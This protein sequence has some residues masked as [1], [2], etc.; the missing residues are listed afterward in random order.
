MEQEKLIANNDLSASSDK[1][2]MMARFRGLAAFIQKCRTPMTVAV[3]GDW[4]TG[5]TTAMN[6]IREQLAGKDAASP[7]LTLWFNTWQFSVLD[8]GGKLIIDLLYMIYQTVTGYSKSWAAAQD[9]PEEQSKLEA[10]RQAAWQK[11][12]KTGQYVKGAAVMTEQLLRKKS[13]EAEWVLENLAEAG[14]GALTD[15]TELSAQ[16]QFKKMLKAHS[17]SSNAG[18][19]LNL[20]Y[21]IRQAV[22]ELFESTGKNRLYFFID[23][24]DR[25]EPGIA[26]EF[27]ECIKNFL[28]IEGLVFVLAV[29][30]SVIE[31]GLRSKYGTD[32]DTWNPERAEK[33]FDKIIQ[34]PFDLPVYS[35]DLENYVKDLLK[36]SDFQGESAKFVE[37]LRT[38]RETN[39]R[40]I[41]RSF[42]LLELYLIMGQEMGNDQA[43]MRNY[44]RYALV[45]LRL[46]SKSDYDLLGEQLGWLSEDDDDLVRHFT[47]MILKNHALAEKASVRALLNVFQIGSGQD[48]S[49]NT[50]AI[51]ALVRTYHETANV[52]AEQQDFSQSVPPDEIVR[53]LYA[54]FR[55]GL[56]PLAELDDGWAVLE[57]ETPPAAEQVE[58]HI[59][60][61]E[62]GGN[63]LMLRWKPGR[64]VNVTVYT[65][66]RD[67]ALAG[68]E[69]SFFWIDEQTGNPDG[70]QYFYSGRPLLVFPKLRC[71]A[72]GCP[73]DTLFRNAHIL[74]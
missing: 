45:L 5:K 14:G 53:R 23:D 59:V 3:Q 36:H 48:D 44:H 17:A 71:Y 73:L 31:R 69:D 42:N 67:A 20:K 55:D 10:I 15:D 65:P 38:F 61:A 56:S 66:D 40:T 52:M 6:I 57:N 51:R 11:L 60:N 28:D 2:G 19:V 68:A 22:E 8:S 34:V 49:D 50:E 70:F 62:S 41:K 30:Q 33:F 12:L 25:L 18:F 9:T 35:Y 74:Q 43:E 27:L 7:E 26:V 39:P 1:L 4:G 24:L 13:D 21:S 46:R 64:Q 47:D 37:I 16:Q 58:L 63:M 32:F 72:A 54:R 29:D